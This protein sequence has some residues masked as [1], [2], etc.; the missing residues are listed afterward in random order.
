MQPQSR[1]A[2]AKWS[3]AVR[4]SQTEFGNEVKNPKQTRNP[5]DENGAL[6]FVL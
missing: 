1:D 2:A 3:F 5:N 6:F 4:R